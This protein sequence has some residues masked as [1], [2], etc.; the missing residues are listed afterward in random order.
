MNHVHAAYSTYCKVRN[1]CRRVR[2]NELRNA[3]VKVIG[4]SLLITFV[5]GG[6][7]KFDHGTLIYE[8]VKLERGE[9]LVWILFSE[10]K[11]WR[12]IYSLSYAYNYHRHVCRSVQSHHKIQLFLKGFTLNFTLIF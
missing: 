6:G 5:G 7:A 11:N 12:V 10:Q 2:K 8:G 4:A 9:R 1:N 3:T